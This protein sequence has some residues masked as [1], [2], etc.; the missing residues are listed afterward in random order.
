MSPISEPVSCI[1][2]TLVA[3]DHEKQSLCC[4]SDPYELQKC[5]YLSASALFCK[6]PESRKDLLD[7]DIFLKILTLHYFRGFCKYMEMQ[8]IIFYH[9]FTNQH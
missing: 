1:E 5:I 4:H 3:Q 6:L 2:D 8:R 7:L 9:V